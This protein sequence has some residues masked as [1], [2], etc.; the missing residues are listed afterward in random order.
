MVCAAT[1]LLALFALTWSAPAALAAE[2]EGAAAPETAPSAPPVVLKTL[3]GITVDTGARE[4]RVESTVCLR[5]GTLELFVCGEGTRE[6]ESVLAV[7]ARPSH[8]TYALA[9]L[10]LQPGKPGYRTVGGA[11]SPPAGE[12]LD[13]TVRFTSPPTDEGDR[14][15]PIEMPAY[16][17][18]RVAGTTNPPR[19]IEWVYVGRPEA[20][21]LKAADEEGT[22]VCLSN[23]PMAVIDVP[24]KSTDVDANLLYEANPETIPPVGT[25]VEIVIKPVGRRKD[26]VKVETEVVVK[27]GE[28]LRLDGKEVDLE[29]LGDAVA[30]MPAVI[31]SAVVRCDPD[32]RVGRVLQ[33]RDALAGALMRVTLIA[34]AAEG[35]P[36]AE[37]PA[38]PSEPVVLQVS[39]NG[40]VC[41]G[42]GEPM[43]LADFTE[44]A[45]DLLEGKDRVT[46]AAGKDV[47]WKVVAELMAAVR[48]LGIA[49]VFVRRVD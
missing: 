3:P 40:Q 36:P 43:A 45:A 20:P 18:L 29:A 44:R 35:E 21:A 46:I 22:V 14:P 17:L 39:A 9:L 27:K 11:F 8:V 15:S 42:D 38:P 5:E 25:P 24:F 4:V 30:R 31:R 34:M 37:P 19:P 26:P 13:I 6:H 47:S 10:G 12:V 7:K 49:D 32:E 33:V 2:K 48:R 16:H 1:V 28:P 41:L 23:F